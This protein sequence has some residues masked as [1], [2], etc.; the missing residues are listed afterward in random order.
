MGNNKAIIRHLIEKL[1]QRLEFTYLG[2]S[3]PMYFP[4]FLFLS[5]PGSEPPHNRH[6]HPPRLAHNELTHRATLQ[7]GSVLSV[8]STKAERSHFNSGGKDTAQTTKCSFYIVHLDD[9]SVFQ[10]WKDPKKIQMFK[11]EYLNILA[12]SVGLK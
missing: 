6:H 9:K 11:V 4:F 7:G 10:L 5:F 2:L 3:A 1:D 8:G 12:A